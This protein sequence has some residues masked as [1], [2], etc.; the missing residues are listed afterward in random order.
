MLSM[1]FKAVP[2]IGRAS[3]GSY[4][5][6]VSSS[7][8]VCCPSKPSLECIRLVTNIFC[9]RSGAVVFA[10]GMRCIRSHG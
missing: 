4:I 6:R 3:I 9:V 1:T 10:C 8:R 2:A 7:Y 5:L